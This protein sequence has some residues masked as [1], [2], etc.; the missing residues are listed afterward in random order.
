QEV[1]LD[2]LGVTPRLPSSRLFASLF[3][4]EYAE[5]VKNFLLRV[6]DSNSLSEEEFQ[7]LLPTGPTP[8]Y[9]SAHASARGIIVLGGTKPLTRAAAIR[10]LRALLR[11]SRGRVADSAAGQAERLARAAHDLRNPIAGILAASQYLL[12]DPPAPR[13]EEHVMLLE[14]IQ[15]SSRF[16]LQLVDDVLGVSTLDA[17]GAHPRREATDIQALL[18]QN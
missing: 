11:R 3:E 2:E 13:S 14:S 6:V 15:A 4:P 12:D 17:G 5:V 16:L 8:L 9:C 18:R 7:V 10:R 1:L